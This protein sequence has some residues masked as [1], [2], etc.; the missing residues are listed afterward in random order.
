MMIVIVSAH[1]LRHDKRI[2]CV[3]SRLCF[4]DPSTFCAFGDTIHAKR[5]LSSTAISTGQPVLAFNWLF[6]EPTASN[7]L[8]TAVA[9]N[10]IEGL[11]FS[12]DS[13]WHP[14]LFESSIPVFTFGGDLDRE[15]SM[16]IDK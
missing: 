12:K 8:E 1:I 11:G 10:V 13:S 4:H 6:Y 16:H 2:T 5:R 3:K 15:E 14:A 9:K 7:R